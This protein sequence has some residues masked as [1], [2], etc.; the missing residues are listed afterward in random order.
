VCSLFSVLYNKTL[1]VMPTAYLVPVI[2]LLASGFLLS[3]FHPDTRRSCC[4]RRSA[5]TLVIDAS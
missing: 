5:S 1:A 4:P 3:L 2:V